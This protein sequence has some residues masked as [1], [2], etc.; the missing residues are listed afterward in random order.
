MAGRLRP[1]SE[2]VF[3]RL[4]ARLRAWPPPS[5]PG[6]EAA[7]DKPDATKLDVTKLD[8]TGGVNGMGPLDSWGAPDVRAAG[9]ISGRIFGLL[10]RGRLCQF[11]QFLGGLGLGLALSGCARLDEPRP[12]AP[13]AESRL[14]PPAERHVEEPRQPDTETPSEARSSGPSPGSVGSVP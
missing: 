11:C 9:L 12:H 2:P 7:S 3:K 4:R 8:V 10:S 1:K 6:E 13:P 14:Y 5:S